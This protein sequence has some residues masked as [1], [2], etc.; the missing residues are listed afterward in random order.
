MERF[1]LLE[2]DGVQQTQPRPTVWD[3]ACKKAYD[4]LLAELAQKEP[5]LDAQLAS[6]AKQGCTPTSS[7]SLYCVSY[8]GQEACLKALP[9][10]PSQCVVDVGKASAALA[11]KIAKQ[12]GKRCTVAGAGQAAVQC[13][14]PW[15]VD[16]CKSTVAAYYAQKTAPWG[17][18]LSIACTAAIDPVFEPGKLK[19]L[20][21]AGALNHKPGG[22]AL[23]ATAASDTGADCKPL[24]DPLSLGCKNHQAVSAQLVQLPQLAVP[25]C[26]PD[27]N[28]DGADAPCIVPVLS[29]GN[30]VPAMTNAQPAVA[31]VAATSAAGR[32]S[33]ADSALAPARA[34]DA[35]P[36]RAGSAPSKSAPV[37][38]ALSGSRG[39]VSPPR[40]GGNESAIRKGDRSGVQSTLPA[41]QSPALRPQLSATQAPAASARAPASAAT[42][43]WGSMNR[44]TGPAP[45][46]ASSAAV[47][48]LA[49]NAGSPAAADAIARELA[50]VFCSAG[51]GGLRF[52]CAT[53]A[54]F[55]RCEALR[56][57]R[58]VERCAFD[59]RR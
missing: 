40:E 5:A 13:T 48:A 21:I 1:P 35:P 34:A 58:K 29:A 56:R 41:V 26:A 4:L 55:D 38:G 9:T 3:H 7:A 28:K 33:S 54:G 8:E 19:A 50:N 36:T 51:R 14:R 37:A 57:E 39:A 59:E 25:Y 23:M 15:K 49:A 10:H 44:E 12:L 17:G 47:P 32:V 52:S 24:W 22:T 46:A 2:G 11:P 6:L 16:Q 27:P 30:L 42:P 53:R 43:N 18:K 45:A 20:E 31:A